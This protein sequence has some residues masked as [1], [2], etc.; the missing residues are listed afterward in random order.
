MWMQQ[1]TNLLNLQKPTLARV[2]LGTN[3]TGLTSGAYT[4]VLLDTED[5][6]AG[7]N[8]ASNKYTVPVTGYYQI[9]W[10]AYIRGDGGTLTSGLS[11]LYKNGSIITYGS[12]FNTGSDI[13]SPGG[14]LQ[15]LTAGDYLEL[16]AVGTTS[17]STWK[18][19]AATQGTF[20]SVHLVSL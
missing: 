4:K 13:V 10:S 8:F 9:N 7:S 19:Q 2:Y 12:Y 5:F 1:V 20:M 15:L 14:D 3:Q 17:S 11:Y 6:D 18:I 16:Y